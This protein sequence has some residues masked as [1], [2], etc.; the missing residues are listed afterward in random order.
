M[1]CYAHPGSTAV[2]SCV[3]C[4]QFVCDVCRVTVEG[5]IHCKVCLEEG[6]GVPWE[7]E[8]GSGPLFGRGGPLYRSRRDKI[9]GGVCGGVADYLGL[10]T[11]LV[12]LVWAVLAFS[13]IPLVLYVVFWAVLPLEPED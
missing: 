6:R 3:S 9:L 1:E 10:D 11:L 2:G 7:K 8:P 12:R 5:R 13:G 4:G